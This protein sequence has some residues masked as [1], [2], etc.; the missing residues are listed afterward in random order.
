[1]TQKRQPK[2]T[3][4]V[5]GIPA[6]AVSGVSVMLQAGAWATAEIQFHPRDA[7]GKATRVFSRDVAKLLGAIQTRCFSNRTEPDASITMDDGNKGSLSF[8]GFSVSPQYMLVAGMVDR[9][10]M[11]VH[12]AAMLDALKLGIYQWQGSD[13][14]AQNKPAN[15]VSWAARIKSAT[16]F[17]V[18]NGASKWKELS[19]SDLELKAQQHQQNQKLLPLWYSLLEDSA[20]ATT[21]EGLAKLNSELADNINR[22]LGST[23]LDYLSSSSDGFWSTISQ[24][25]STFQLL[26]VPG[27]GDSA[28]RLIRLRDVLGKPQD[29]EVDIVECSFT[30]GSTGVVPLQQVL[31]QGKGDAK[32]NNTDEKPPQTLAGWPERPENTTGQVLLTA[33]PQWLMP[34]EAVAG[35]AFV[36]ASVR[37]AAPGISDTINIKTY[38]EK[39]SSI[40]QRSRLVQSEAVLM[41][42]REYVRNLYSDRCLAGTGFSMTV[43]LNLKAQPGTRYTVKEGSDTLF[44][45]FL[46]SVTHT[47]EIPPGGAQGSA[48]TR[49]QFSHV[50]LGDF[51]VPGK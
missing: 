16:E 44:E 6:T 39:F 31:V 8:K 25:C 10:V 18:K 7:E 4:D 27:T 11:L 48:A 14:N 41:L 9:K 43:P 26:Y 28:G 24:L 34:L 21:S 2:A 13:W 46:A 42:L 38:Q 45:G 33:L 17:L 19:N 15:G 35:G 29:M 22:G 5:Q 37:T 40:I 3:C 1:M 20:E 47:M 50:E 51:K 36:P 12:R 32:W 23:I 49:L 30:N